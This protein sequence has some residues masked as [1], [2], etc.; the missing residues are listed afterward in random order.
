MLWMR[1]ASVLQRTAMGIN[2]AVGR[3]LASKKLPVSLGG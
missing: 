3:D 1:A 2:K